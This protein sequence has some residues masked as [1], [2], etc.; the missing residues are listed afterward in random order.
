MS[1]ARQLADLGNVYDDGALSNRNMVTNGAMLVNQRGNRSPAGFTGGFYAG[2]DRWYVNRSGTGATGF[3]QISSTSYGG[4]KAAEASFLCA[5]GETYIVTQR[6]EADNIAH[7]AGQTV[8]LS[9]WASGSSDAGSATLNASLSYAGAVNDFTSET[10][11]SS[12]AVSY[13]GSAQRFTFTFTLPANAANGVAIRFDGA[14]TSATGTF[15]LTFGGVQLETGDTATPFEHELSSVTLQ[16][17]QR[18]YQNV[19]KHGNANTGTYYSTFNK[20]YGGEVQFQTMRT[21]PSVSYSHPSGAFYWVNPGVVAFSANST[22]GFQYSAQQPNTSSTGTI[23]FIQIR[24][25]G[26]ATPVDGGSYRLEADI[27]FHLDAEL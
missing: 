22:S 25:A 14:K 23:N 21:A 8:T 11:I 17:C 12:N 1:K 2:P 18:F 4:T 20:F 9:F 15:T 26:N 10:V 24:Q 27:I 16:K 19:Y 6:I 3:S 5:S 7:L 13:S